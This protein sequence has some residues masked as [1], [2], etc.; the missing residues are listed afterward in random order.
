MAI[1]LFIINVKYWEV[2]IGVVFILL[3]KCVQDYLFEL[4]VLIQL[5]CKFNNSR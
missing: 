1:C 5:K 3:F 2:Y 4:F